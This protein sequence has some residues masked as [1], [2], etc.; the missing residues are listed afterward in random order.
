M[1]LG[2]LGGL[3]K[4]PKGVRTR[5]SLSVWAYA[6]ALALLALAAGLLLERIA[7]ADAVEQQQAAR[8][9][10]GVQSAERLAARLGLWLRAEQAR[11]QSLA[12]TELADAAYA[13]G[14][15]GELAAAF[16]DAIR[17]EVVAAGLRTPRLD[18]EPPI[19]YALLEMM[20]QAEKEHRAP[21]AEVHLP[22]QPGAHANLLQPVIRDGDVVA[23][24]VV[25]YP[26]ARLRELL[27]IPGGQ[28]ALQQQGVTLLGNW[29]SAASAA[30]VSGSRWQVGFVPQAGEA[31]A[32]SAVVR[33]APLMTAAFAALLLLGLAAFIVRALRRDSRLVETL[34]LDAEMGRLAPDYAPSLR[35]LGPMLERLRNHLQSWQP[36]ERGESATPEPVAPYP[37][38]DAIVVED[39]VSEQPPPTPAAEEPPPVEEPALEFVQLQEGSPEPTQPPRIPPSILRAYDVRGIVGDTLTAE[40]VHLLARAIGTEAA[41]AGQQQVVVARDGRLS[42]DELAQALVD[43]LLASGRDVINIGQVPTPVMNFAVHHLGTGAGVMVTGSHNPREYNGLKIVIGGRTLSGEA[44]QALGR[45]AEAGDFIEGSGTVI[46]QDVREAYIERIVT[47]ATLQRPLRI[48]IDCGNGVAGALAPDVFR[49]MGCEVEELFCEVDGYFPNHHPDPT[50]PANLDALVS[51]VRLQGADLGLAFDG[52]ADRLGVVDNKGRIIWADRQM[53]MFAR[54][55]LSRHPGSDIVFDVKCSAK[56]PEVIAEHAGVPVMWKTGHSMIRNKVEETGA[57]LGGELSGHIFFA[58]RWYGFDDAIYA[59]ARLLEILSA[60]PR[61]ADELFAE[62]P[63]SIAT[64]ELRTDLQE[65]EPV[66][67]MSLLGDRL[68][69]ALKGASLTLIDGIR[70]DFPDGW[71]LVRASNTTPSLVFRFEGDDTEALQ[72]IQEIFRE[73]LLAVEPGLE[74]PF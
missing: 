4:K 29:N 72:R 53:M 35:E 62:L 9:S 41:Q 26:V 44:I 13:L 1:D 10:M 21:P 56:L 39:V 51:L 42:S 68:G 57:M 52:D 38:A 63:D 5:R 71:G 69:K 74:L 3:G 64:P 58:D 49:A 70:A 40:I 8:E 33:Y 15:P 67:I 65:G 28:A 12:E 36:T 6:A 55:V 22:G 43:G 73:Q 60:D 16:P 25:T 66:R 27:Q 14:E 23:H 30:G 48:V 54:D 18:S 59:G 20:R 45:R 50:V 32:T 61:P 11:L 7:Y 17:V 34:L 24:L 19:G 37:A 47:D 31:A 46:E 2:K